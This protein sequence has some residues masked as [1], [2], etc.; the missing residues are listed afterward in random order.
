M[1]R[2][3]L[4]VPEDPGD[5]KVL[6]D[7]ERYGFNVRHVR[8]YHHPEHA[9]LNPPEG[10]DPVSAIG[11]SYTVGLPHS[12]R[13]PEL[14]VVTGEPAE[15]AHDLLWGVVALIDGGARFGP[16]DSS[17]EVLSEGTV[18]FGDVHRHWRKE[19]LTF[20]DWAARRRPFAAVQIVLPVR[21]P[22]PLLHSR[23]L[24]A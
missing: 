4:P 13:H 8:P 10:L 18:T 2:P 15:V 5:E 19:L 20:A 17:G 9:H 23:R 11:F 6:A 14:I 21:T 12:R 16:G 7:I 22:Q 24:S 1:R 3:V